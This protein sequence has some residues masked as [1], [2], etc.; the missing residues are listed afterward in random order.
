VRGFLGAAA[1]GLLAAGIGIAGLFAQADNAFA[2]SLD[3]IG[4]FGQPTYVTSDPG[5]PDRIFVLEQ[6]GRIQLTASGQTT[7][8]VDLDS[9]VLSAGEP[10]AGN[11]QGLLSV[12]FAPD[13]ETSARLYVAYSGMDAGAL[14]VDELTASGDVADLATRQPVLTVA[15]PNDPAHYGGQLQFGPDGYLY[16]STGDAGTCCYDPQENAQ[17]Y[18]SLLGKVLRIDPQPGGGYIV[19]ADNPFVGDAGAAPEIWALGLRNPWRFSFDRSTGAL[20]L[21]DVGQFAWE[22]VNYEPGPDAGRGDNYGWPC[23]EGPGSGLECAGTFTEPVFAYPHDEGCAITGGYVVRDPDLDELEG[24]YVYS[25]FCTGEVRSVGLPAT[26]GF[27]DCSEG[28]SVQRPTSF[29]EDAAGRVYVASRLGPVYRLVDGVP[30]NCEAPAPSPPP[31]PTPSLGGPE[32]EAVAPVLTIGGR[33]TQS[34][35]RERRLSLKVSADRPGTLELAAMVLADGDLLAG[36]PARTTGLAA[37]TERIKWTLSREQA[38]RA[39]RAVREGRRV[40]VLFEGVAID[41]GME[42]GT[43]VEFE[44]RLVLGKQ[45]GGFRERRSD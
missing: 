7:T 10:G 31:Q 6:D 21:P 29:G 37:G 20:V 33:E 2:V 32:E 17:D 13:Y 1:R 23:R 14:H 38:R 11:E 30:A 8:F 26:G 24:R 12:A 4:T 22:E 15:H 45:P 39:R 42:R 16:I 18:E 27:D 3:Q 5:D 9:I 43:P 19:P 44:V 41:H 28:V 34:I 25:D 36:L 35:K 40:T